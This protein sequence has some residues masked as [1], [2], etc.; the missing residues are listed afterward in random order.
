M[1]GLEFCVQRWQD[2]QCEGAE[3]CCPCKVRENVFILRRH[4]CERAKFYTYE[5]VEILRSLQM[6]VNVIIIG[7]EKKFY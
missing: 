3:F 4:P 7:Y 6:F 1:T 2:D 5:N